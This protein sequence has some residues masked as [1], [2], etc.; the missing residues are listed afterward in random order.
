MISQ[1]G[2]KAVKLPRKEKQLVSRGQ[3]T[4]WGLSM[5]KRDRSSTDTTDANKLHSSRSILADLTREENETCP[6]C[7]DILRIDGCYRCYRCNYKECG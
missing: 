5:E 3:L 6:I 2:E 7:G 4:L 1:V